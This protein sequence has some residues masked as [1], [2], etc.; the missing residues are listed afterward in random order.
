VGQSMIR[1]RTQAK[2]QCRAPS[3]LGGLRIAIPALLGVCVAAAEQPVQALPGDVARAPLIATAVRLEDPAQSLR[4]AIQAI[5]SDRHDQAIW[6]LGEVVDRHPIVADHAAL[7]QARLLFGDGHHEAAAGV[8]RNALV[9]SP[10]SPL[11]PEF[12]ALLGDALEQLGDADGALAAWRACLDVE[13]DSAA[14]ARVLQSIAALE[15]ERGLDRGAADTYKRIWAEYP[16]SGSALT[17]DERL[18][19]FEQDLGTSLR[20]ARDWRQRGDRLFRASDNEAA[21]Q[22][23]E[24]ALDVG[25]SDS[26]ARLARRQRA[27]TLFRLR[28]Y[29]EA[30]VAYGELPQTDDVPIWRARSM[31]RAGQVPESIAEFERLAESGADWR[32]VRARFLAALLLD[33][34]QMDDRAVAHYRVVSRSARGAGMADAADWRLGWTAYRQGRYD[35]AVE[36]FDLLIGRTKGDP[37][38]QLRPRYWRARALGRQGD[39][40]AE[41]E[42]ASIA[43]TYP[44]TYYGW[45]S[46]SRTSGALVDTGG[47]APLDSARRIPPSA[48]ARAHI[49]LEAGLIEAA[50]DEIGLLTDRARALSDRLE[51]AQLASDAGDFARAQGLVVGAYNTTLARGPQPRYEDLWWY[52]WPSAYASLVDDASRRAGGVDPALV[53]AIMREESGYRAKVV[54]PV[55]ARGLMQI[56]MPTGQR[57]AESMGLASY[58]HDDLFEPRINIGL[59][60]HYLAQ[61]SKR[62]DGRLS[63]AIASYNA[64]PEAV[65]EWTLTA[66][67]D[68]DEWV[69]SI[70]YDQ[71]REYVRRVLRSMHAYRVLY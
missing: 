11:R 18:R 61:L 45:R 5:E 65:S 39:A 62:F 10:G 70:P 22:S 36:Y 40:R 46:R 41:A 68:D 51:L 31:A 25:L 55:G 52:A 4:A 15:D 47:V 14:R 34:R 2:L 3:R 20:S 6:L 59:G 69:E 58:E 67:E 23:Y 21:L 71:T 24:H 38:D 12:H 27:H 7:I 35:E 53:Y 50:R 42:F 66:P 56:M 54:S 44:F 33:G 32:A 64:G 9:H 28:R 43:R 63:A 13:R 48:L 30:L 1:N 17:A 37:I 60:S 16:T 57:L 49:L 19:Q 26:E 29:P 8:A